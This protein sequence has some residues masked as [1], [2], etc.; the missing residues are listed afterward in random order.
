MAEAEE[1][2]E[3]QSHADDSGDPRRMRLHMKP[4]NYVQLCKYPHRSLRRMI[5]GRLA[6]VACECFFKIQRA[7]Q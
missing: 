4:T 5:H 1:I 6:L 7:V 3:I 2:M